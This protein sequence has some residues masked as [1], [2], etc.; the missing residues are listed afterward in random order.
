MRR[1]NEL[2][3]TITRL[4]NENKLEINWSKK[5]KNKENLINAS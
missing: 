3:K 5:F 1:N 2:E 4:L